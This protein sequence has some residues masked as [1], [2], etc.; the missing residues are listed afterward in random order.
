MLVVVRHRRQR[1]RQPQAIDGEQLRQ[2][3]AQ[4]GRRRRPLPLHPRGILLQLPHALVGLQFPSRAQRR[5]RLLVLRL[6][7][8][9]E[10]V[11]HLVVPA[12]L[13]QVRL[14]EHVTDG[15][16]QR[17]GAVDH[18]QPPA[19]GPQPALDQLLQPGPVVTVAFSDGP[20]RRPSTCFRPRA[21]TPTAASTW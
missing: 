5:P 8:M 13:N 20:S 2:S 21:S 17:L 15:A 7:Q 18:E 9:A 1:L 10:H 14:A 12:A 3:F 4:A 11:P 16:A 19:V 6:G